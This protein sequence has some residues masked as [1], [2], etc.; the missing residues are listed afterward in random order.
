MAERVTVTELN[1][2]VKDLLESTPY[3]RD[4]WL[5]GE[6]S[7]FKTYS[8]GHS[9][10]TIKDAGGAISAV[11]FRGARSRLDFQPGDSM[12]IEAFGSVSLYPQNGSYQFVVQ[13]M[14]RS[15]VGELYQEYEKLKKKLEAEE[16]FDSSRKRPIPRYPKTIG[17]VTSP[18]GA[19]IHDILTT[20]KRLWPADILLAPA[21][22]Q[23]EGSAKS[24]VEGIELLN[25]VGVDII[26]VGRGGGSIED[27]WAF[28]EEPVVRA[29]AASRI[30]VISS[31]GHETDV[32]LADFAADKRA[33][34]P[35]GAAEMAV[36]DKAEVRREV[37]DLMR[38]AGIGLQT[39]W[40]KMHRDFELLDAKLRPE[41]A[42]DLVDRKLMELD[43]LER[44]AGA[45]LTRKVSVMKES[46]SAVA[47]RP[48]AA[49]MGTASRSR[50][51]FEKMC[52]NL[53]P[54]M[55]SILQEA[56]S[57]C[58]ELS[59]G[60]DALSPYSVLERGYSF[61]A[62]PDGRAITTVKDLEVGSDITVR[63]ADGRA[64]AHIT[65]KE[66]FQ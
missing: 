56:R 2:R 7:N 37:E 18:T 55:R 46:Y 65:E 41:K 45:V 61:V 25:K 63:M 22:V 51:R 39:A 38:R 16:L 10:F 4:F 15:G 59:V 64:K 47:H 49:L 52:Q 53:E 1:N 42:A 60:L 30:P 57:D 48:E 17:V 58:S 33:P 12:K 36:R 62:G 44:R 28:N 11:L 43:D 23:G 19:V 31:V 35:T 40:G 66:E 13:T 26:I 21:K 3:L 24:I 50:L 6:I 32:T 20:T 54:Q 9:Y 29:I 8:S 14:R 5:V 34:T 27:L